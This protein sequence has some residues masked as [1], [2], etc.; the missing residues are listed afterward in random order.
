MAGMTAAHNAV[1]S[2]ELLA[3]LN[4]DADLAA[5]AQDWAHH[6]HHRGEKG[7]NANT[8]VSVKTNSNPVDVVSDWASEFKNYNHATG[9]CEKGGECEH[10]SRMISESVQSLGCGMAYC[11]EDAHLDGVHGWS[12]WICIYNR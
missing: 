7:R 9:M 12:L 2:R 11:D 3:P 4:W 10:Y 5:Q 1:R 6:C 8:L